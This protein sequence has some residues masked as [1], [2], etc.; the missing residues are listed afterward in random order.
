MYLARS[1]TMVEYR[2]VVSITVQKFERFAI[3]RCYYSLNFGATNPYSFMIFRLHAHETYFALD[4]H[5][6]RKQV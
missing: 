5:F 1:F 3:I 4:S 6:L 2:L